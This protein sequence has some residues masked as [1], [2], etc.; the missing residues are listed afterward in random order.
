MRKAFVGLSS[1]IGYNYY[2]DFE[3][4]IG[5]PNPIL[6][7]PMGLFLFY[8]EI[9]FI[10]RRTCPFNCENLYYVKFLDEEYDLTKLD[11]EQFSWDNLE[12]EKYIPK[13][14]MHITW[15][16]WKPTVELNVGVGKN[17]VDNHGRSFNIG[18]IHATPNPTAINL[19]LDDFL[20]NYFGFELITNSVTSIL[21]NTTTSKK[22]NDL[23]RNL[24]QFLLC[25]NIPN[26][27]LIDGPYHVLIEELRTEDLLKEFRKKIDNTT[28]NRSN[29]DLN[30]LKLDLENSMNDYLYGLILKNLDQEQIYKALCNVTIGQ[31]PVL[32][33]I[34]GAL[35]G[36]M[37]VYNNIKDRKEVGWIGFV[38]KSRLLIK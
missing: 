15:D 27:Q 28:Q 21:A 6:D 20:A 34:Y 24:I 9:W 33:N 25:S 12:I 18:K 11:L 35:E 32:G 2:Y 5:R 36:G 7:S 10:N 37:T 29:E 8:D 31:I 38:A 14:K 3:K 19:I 13:D 26:F 16:I 22:Q 1:P 23:E 30:K 17:G 4:K